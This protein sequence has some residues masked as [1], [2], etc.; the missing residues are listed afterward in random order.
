MRERIQSELWPLARPVWMLSRSGTPYSVALNIKPELLCLLVAR[1]ECSVLPSCSP[2]SLLTLS[3]G[4]GGRR[5]GGGLYS[6]HYWDWGTAQHTTLY[7]SDGL[8]GTWYWVV[9]GGTL[10]ISIISPHLSSPQLDN[11]TTLS[12]PSRQSLGG[13]RGEVWDLTCVVEDQPAHVV[14]RSNVNHHHTA[15]CTPLWSPLSLSY[16]HE[17]VALFEFLSHF[18]NSIVEQFLSIGF[19]IIILIFHYQINIRL[20]QQH[21]WL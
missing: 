7:G 14:L 11:K 15:H 20:C 9:S 2:L 3:V 19:L 8:T 13:A 21:P 18:Q 4:C 16:K 10:S 12:L 5:R 17:R 6:S 1:E